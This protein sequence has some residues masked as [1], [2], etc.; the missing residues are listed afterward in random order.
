VVGVPADRGRTTGAVPRPS[1]TR[2]PALVDRGGEAEAI[3]RWGLVAI[4]RRFAR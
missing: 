4:E 1:E 3:G 2:T